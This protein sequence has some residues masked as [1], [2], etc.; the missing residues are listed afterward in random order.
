MFERPTPFS[1]RPIRAVGLI[2]HRGWTLKRYDIHIQGDPLDQAVYDAGC[3]FALALL[4]FPG[5]TA[6]RPGVGF[7]VPATG[8]Q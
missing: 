5:E 6:Q 2:E 1:P 4:P 7:T 3:A 8:I